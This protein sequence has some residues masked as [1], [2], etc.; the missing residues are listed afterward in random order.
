MAGDGSEAPAGLVYRPDLLDEDEERAA[1][2][3][4]EG[5]DYAEVVMRGQVAKR[6]VRHFGVDYLYE[7][8]K[9]VETDPLP[10]ELEWLRDR[11]GTFAEIDPALLVECL[12]TRYPEGAGIGWHRDAPMFGPTVIG[13]S[14]LAPATMRFQRG[15]GADRRTYAL[16][17]AP[18]SGYL[19]TGATRTAWQHSIPA[20]KALR[21]SVTFRTMRR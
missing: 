11:A 17:L 20:T 10:G 6:S 3:V 13:L 9:V 16:A 12:V 15:K 4:I 2:Q 14:L 7:S 1:L 8:W 18:R 19:L 21:Y 5:L